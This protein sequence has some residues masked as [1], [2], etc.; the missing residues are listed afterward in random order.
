[1]EVRDTPFRE[2]VSIEKRV[3]VAL[4]RLAS[5]DAYRTVVSTFGNGK[6]TAVEITNSF[7][8]ALN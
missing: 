8:D 1:M 2:A 4:W 3:A 7:I 6:S 5:G